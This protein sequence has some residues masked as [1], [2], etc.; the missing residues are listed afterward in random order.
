[1]LDKPT[2]TRIFTGI[3]FGTFAIAVWVTW[4]ADR[5]TKMYEHMCE[6]YNVYCRVR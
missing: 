2:I 1:M 5:D 6:N 3:V 4:A